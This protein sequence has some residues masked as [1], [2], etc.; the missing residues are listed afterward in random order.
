VA[1]LPAFRG[2]GYAAAVTAAWGSAMQAAGGIPLYTTAWENLAS[3]GVAR[4]LG[5]WQYGTD[6]WWA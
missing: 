1:T 3:Q 5:L 4:R 6:W 2:Q